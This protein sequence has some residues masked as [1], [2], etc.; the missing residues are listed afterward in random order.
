MY[1]STRLRTT[2]AGQSV[3]VRGQMS[4]MPSSFVR[5]AI[6]HLTAALHCH[7]F[8]PVGFVKLYCECADFNPSLGFTGTQQ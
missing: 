8:G 2:H 3:T 4:V 6:D 5:G 1:L 7:S